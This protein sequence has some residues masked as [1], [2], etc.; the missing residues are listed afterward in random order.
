MMQLSCVYFT[1]MC[2]PQE[3][4]MG[5]FVIMLYKCPYWEAFVPDHP[6]AIDLYCACP[7]L[8]HALVLKLVSGYQGGQWT[9][10]KFTLVIQLI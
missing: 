8:S 1:F 3:E 7:L 10:C 5:H 6:V 4:L 9:S 2:F